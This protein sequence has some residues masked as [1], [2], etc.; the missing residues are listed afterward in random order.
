MTI[1]ITLDGNKQASANYPDMP[2]QTG[3]AVEDG[4]IGHQAT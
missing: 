3:Q 4:G 1:E 2:P